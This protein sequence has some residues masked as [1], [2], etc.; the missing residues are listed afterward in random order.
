[1]LCL[2]M[3][4]HPITFSA[5][6]TASL[7][8]GCGAAAPRSTAPPATPKAERLQARGERFVLRGDVA[9]DEFGPLALLGRYT[10]AFRQIG[11]G[12][13]FSAE[14]PFTARLEQDRAGGAPRRI[15]LFERATRT[16]SVTVTARGRWRLVVDFGDLPFEV[17]L[18]PR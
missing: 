15:D 16:G 14:V 12:V 4:G 6:L 9:P 3:R 5:V 11:S 13:D 8:V 17:T 10:V 2:G 1:M 7:A 18:T